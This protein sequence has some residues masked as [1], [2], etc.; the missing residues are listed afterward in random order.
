VYTAVWAHPTGDST[1][2]AA[3]TTNKEKEEEISQED[4]ETAPI[5]A[6][7]TDSDSA[8]DV[9]FDLS[10]LDDILGGIQ[11]LESAFGEM[12]SSLETTLS[13]M[14]DSTPEERKAK[15]DGLKLLQS[16]LSE[17]GDAEASADEDLP[18]LFRAGRE[19]KQ[20]KAAAEA[21]RAVAPAHEE[22]DGDSEEDETGLVESATRSSGNPQLDKLTSIL[23]TFKEFLPKTI[24]NPVTPDVHWGWEDWHWHVDLDKAH[25]SQRGATPHGSNAAAPFRTGTV[26]DHL[27]GHVS[28]FGPAAGKYRMQ[29]RE[30]V[31]RA[32]AD[33]TKGDN[34][35]GN[36]EEDKNPRVGKVD[37]PAKKAQK[38]KKGGKARAKN[39]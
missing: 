27:F 20:Q 22:E 13:T 11:G 10:G 1:T 21:L 6:A 25:R 28:L 2:A 30:K 37:Q 26:L 19:Q 9:P 34:T 24:F 29:V 33:K 14:K 5:P 8:A 18:M 39:T 35:Q 36:N 4:A 23:T 32:L 15:A 7:A 38:G 17:D 16:L 31:L 12:A 3:T